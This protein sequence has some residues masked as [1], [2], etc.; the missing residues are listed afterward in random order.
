MA[1]NIA[2]DE[3]AQPNLHRWLSNMPDTPDHI[4]RQLIL[5]GDDFKSLGTIPLPDKHV[6]TSHPCIGGD[7]R[8]STAVVTEDA[9]LLGYMDGNIEVFDL[10]TL[11]LRHQ[12][13]GLRKPVTQMLVSLGTPLSMTF[14][15]RFLKDNT[16]LAAG[17]NQVYAWPIKVNKIP[18]RNSTLVHCTLTDIVGLCDTRLGPLIA[19]NTG[20]IHLIRQGTS[21][22][23]ITAHL[24]TI[25]EFIDTLA[26]L[27]VHH[28][29]NHFN[30]YTDVGIVLAVSRYNWF[31][32]IRVFEN[33]NEYKVDVITKVNIDQF[34]HMPRLEVMITKYYI[35][36]T[37]YHYGYD[38]IR[39][40]GIVKFY[41][42][43]CA[44]NDI[45]A[46]DIYV[47]GGQI[48]KWSY[49]DSK[50]MLITINGFISIYT[51]P[52]LDLLTVIITQDRITHAMAYKDSAI[53]NTTRGYMIIKEIPDTKVSDVRYI[54]GDCRIKFD[55][56]YKRFIGKATYIMCYHFYIQL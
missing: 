8:V 35:G 27:R 5:I 14:N 7:R 31:G 21:G 11:K 34:E 39:S 18:N 13:T 52:N 38:D 47:T 17:G 28:F 53:I 4:K 45:K 36:L 1:L 25:N 2:C 26:P 22:R 48:T 44:I 33:I 30:V 24:I 42:L 20:E 12:L 3:I 49:T 50:L 15:T 41:S 56:V 16:I 51:N 9:I 46:K 32:L 43:N 10:K 6:F 29:P 54:C 19:S 37:A 23:L 55:F 40:D